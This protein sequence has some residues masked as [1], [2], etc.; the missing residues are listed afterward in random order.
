MFEPQNET[1]PTIAANSVGICDFSAQNDP[2]DRKWWRYSIQAMIATAPPP[3][4]LNIATICGIAV[5]RTFRAAGTPIA[6][7]MT[8]PRAISHGVLEPRQHMRRQQRG[9]DRD[10]HADGRDL[11]PAHR[12]ARPRQPAQAVDEQRERD[13]VAGVD[14]VRLLQE[15]RG[16]HLPS[17]SDLVRRSVPRRQIGLAL[18]HPE[19]PVGDQEAADDVDRAERDRDHQQHVLQHAVRLVHQQQTAEQHDPVDRVG[20]RHQ[21]R[22]QRVRDLR[23]HLEADECGQHEDRDLGNG[24]HVL[25]LRFR[26]SWSPPTRP[27]R[28]RPRGRSR[29]RG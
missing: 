15:D 14:E 28:G 4:P 12:R 21:R 11:V 8:S 29:R 5:I 18:E 22:V 17:P 20:A 26:S 23:D 2:P 10:R 6:V 7:P 25:L 13:D 9:H 16:D 24:A 1:E 3:T 27:P 19:H